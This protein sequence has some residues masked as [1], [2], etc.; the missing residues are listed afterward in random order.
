MLGQ[1]P[2]PHDIH[3]SRY[4]TW[5]KSVNKIGSVSAFMPS[6]RQKQEDYRGI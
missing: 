2:D 3:V 6:T 4:A 1:R 5:G